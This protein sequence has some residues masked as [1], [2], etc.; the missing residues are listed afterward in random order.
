[1]QASS[2]SSLSTTTATLCLQ[3]IQRF[4]Q[5]VSG[6]SELLQHLDQ[7]EK[8]RKDTIQQLEHK[9]SDEKQKTAQLQAQQR[10]KMNE[11]VEQYEQKQRKQLT[12]LQTLRRK[13]TQLVNSSATSR[14]QQENAIRNLKTSL[15]DAKHDKKKTIKRMKQETS[16]TREKC[17]EYEQLIEEGRRLEKQAAQTKKK[18]ERDLS[19]AWSSNKKLGEEN[20]ALQLQLKHM[21]PLAP[22][23]LLATNGQQEQGG[24]S[25]LNGTGSLLPTPPT[26]T[27]HQRPFHHNKRPK[28]KDNAKLI[29]LQQNVIERKQLILR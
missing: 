25:R 7:V 11:L 10:Q 21:S 29:S 6:K 8:Q 12:E 24:A 22:R 17:Q 26:S 28:K 14:T 13:H 20:Q 15:E 1:M 16:R 19:Q 3:L 27:L 5:S 2:P 9:L 18:L 23:K 4:Q